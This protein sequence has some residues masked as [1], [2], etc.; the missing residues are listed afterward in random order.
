MGIK[1]SIGYATQRWNVYHGC[2]NGCPYCWARNFAYR[3]R[4]RCGYP[5]DDPF[6][7]VFR[8]D[9]LNEP[10]H[11]RKP[12]RVFVGFMGELG[13]VSE[14]NFRRVLK[15]VED[16]PAHQFLFLSKMPESL[17]WYNPWPANAWVGVTVTNSEQEEHAAFCL[18][19]VDATVRWISWEPLLEHI[20][21]SWD[22][23]IDW[24]VIGACTGPKARQFPTKRAWVDTIVRWA[25]RRSLPVYL[26]DNL[27][28]LFL[29]RELRQ[30]WPDSLGTK[31]E[32]SR[33]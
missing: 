2:R 5:Q 32:N 30:E 25:D 27:G 22:L 12:R 26:K 10:Y 4:G 18:D 21:P 29:N 13:Y 17:P 1:E 33:H 9:R 14:E 31:D 16:N 20:E 24:V 8:E 11:W 23:D 19:D 15:V 3:L 28:S 7:P 6:R